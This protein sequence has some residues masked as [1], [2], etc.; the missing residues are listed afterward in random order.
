MLSEGAKFSYRI[1]KTI[2]GKPEGEPVDTVYMV[3]RISE[4]CAEFSDGADTVTV[5]A[6]Y[7][8]VFSIRGMSVSGKE[9]IDT[10][11][12]TVECDVYEPSEMLCGGS[13][14]AYVCDGIAYVVMK[15]QLWSRGVRYEEK[16]IL[17]GIDA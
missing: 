9:S 4:E 12:G 13:S 7:I 8:P 15:S 16:W 17:T 5:R 3:T 2:D 11:R 6:P 10:F 14:K 1:S